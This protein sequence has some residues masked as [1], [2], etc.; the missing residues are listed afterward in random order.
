MCAPLEDCS[1]PYKVSDSRHVH[2]LTLQLAK[3][4][5]VHSE[6]TVL[7]S[8]YS[9]VQC[10]VQYSRVKYR[11]QTYLPPPPH[12][13]LC[14]PTVV[15]EKT[16]EEVEGARVTQAVVHMLDISKTEFS[17]MSKAI[18]DHANIQKSVRI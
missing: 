7:R 3:D 5:L 17:P 14:A 16:D 15:P 6:L 4:L 11:V 18:W 1:L 2:L 10:T 12:P 9:T 13:A 8:L